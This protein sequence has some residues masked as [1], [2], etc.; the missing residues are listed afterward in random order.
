MTAKITKGKYI[1]VSEDVVVVVVV[2]VVPV[3]F[4]VLVVVVVVVGLETQVVPVEV[5]PVGQVVTQPLFR[6]N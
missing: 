3:V 6:S 4:V 2:L 1:K 5:N